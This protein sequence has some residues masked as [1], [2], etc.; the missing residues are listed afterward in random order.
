MEGTG[1]ER[2]CATTTAGRCAASPGR[3]CSCRCGPR[4]PH[5][6]SSTRS[7]LVSRQCRRPGS[8]GR[9]ES[10][11]AAAHHPCLHLGLPVG[12]AG[13]QRARP[14]NRWWWPLV[15]RLRATGFDS[16]VL[17]YHYNDHLCTTVPATARN[18]ALANHP[19]VSHHCSKDAL[20][21]ASPLSD[22]QTPPHVQEH[23]PRPPHTHAHTHARMHKDAHKHARARVHTHPPTHLEL[24]LPSYAVLGRPPLRLLHLPC[25][26]SSG[27]GTAQHSTPQ[28]HRQRH[29][30]AAHRGSR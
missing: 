16:T 19:H 8:S 14:P 27:S 17:L 13:R 9:S 2:A 15:P 22:I 30:T 28:R 1:H 6:P 5:F 3:S 26:T 21:A 18:A 7:L 23:A 29:T 20:P 12:A 4:R 10:R 11:P 24:G 25:A